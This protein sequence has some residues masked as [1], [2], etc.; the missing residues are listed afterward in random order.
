MTCLVSAGRLLLFGMWILVIG[1]VISILVKHL[2]EIVGGFVF[3]VIVVAVVIGGQQVRRL[4]VVVP[5]A[6]ILV[7]RP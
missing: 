3:V 1:M 6:R 7:R 5:Q 4:V 2:G